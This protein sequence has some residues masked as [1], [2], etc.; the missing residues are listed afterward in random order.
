[1]EGSRLGPWPGAPCRP[2]PEIPGA[3][4]DRRGSRRRG[5]PWIYR[6]QR[7]RRRPTALGTVLLASL[8]AS[9]LAVAVLATTNPAT[10]SAAPER[11]SG[12]LRTSASVGAPTW[13]T[14]WTRAMD[15]GAKLPA[16][17]TTVRDIAHVAEGGTSVRFRLSNA[18]GSAPAVFSSVTVG[19][20]ESGDT[21]EP[22]SLHQVTFAGSPS[23]TVPV[24]ADVTSDPV[25]LAVHPGEALAVSIWLSDTTLVTQHYW[26]PGSGT[27]VD[28]YV[29]TNG[30]GNLTETATGAPFFT[31]DSDMRW[32]SAVEVAGSPANGTAVAFG[33]SITD[34]FNNSGFGWPIPLQERIDRLAPPRRMAVVDEGIAGNTLTRFPPGRTYS[35]GDAGHAGV[36]RLGTD[37]LDLPGV[38]D[39]LLLLG[40]NDIWFGGQDHIPPYGSAPSI[41]AGMEQVIAD[42][43]AK[44]VGVIGLTL[45]PRASTR[46]ELWT[47]AEQATLEAVNTWMLTPG[48]GFGAVVNVAAVMGDVYNGACAPT[49]PFQPYYTD[50][51]LHPDTAGQIALADA[52]PTSLLGIP[53]AP[54]IPQ[55]ASVRAVPTPGCTGALDAE[56]VMDQAQA[57]A[58]PVVTPVPPSTSSTSTSP[59]SSPSTPS[60]GQKRPTRSVASGRDRPGRGDPSPGR[61]WELPVVVTVVVVTSVAA[62]LVARVRRRRSRMGHP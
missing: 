49:T 39:V 17:D 62:V 16:T 60:T 40:T 33:D 5:R 26:R 45:L 46:E 19:V 38:K 48:N 8:L 2:G 61:P 53:E 18:W 23:V 9:L 3:G 32:L 27:P 7:T 51:G 25:D 55:I 42:A 6:N 22:G 15:W 41:I 4:G 57:P 47:P 52:I 28:S 11:R 44:G 31:G 30:S 54:Q 35:T 20:Q 59:T 56:F 13:Q 34:G 10:A 1:M 24:G 58:G 37:A 12:G 14:V 43:H 29:A 21:V 50:D 36:T